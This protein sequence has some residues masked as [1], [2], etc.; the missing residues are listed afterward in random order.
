MN[1]LLLLDVEVID[2]TV[3]EVGAIDADV[4]VFELAFEVG[5]GLER[6]EEAPPHRRDAGEERDLPTT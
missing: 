4:D 2:V 3:E 6:V 1:F 5:V